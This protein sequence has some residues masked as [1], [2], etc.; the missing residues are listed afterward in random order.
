M[1]LVQTKLDVYSDIFD[2]ETEFPEI[3]DEMRKFL[4]RK[5]EE[6]MSESVRVFKVTP[7][8]IKVEISDNV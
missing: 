5:V 3:N 2:E 8:N 6:Y 1:Y 4:Q 7:Y